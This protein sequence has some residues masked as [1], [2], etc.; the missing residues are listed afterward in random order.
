[1]LE[2][3]LSSLLC[4]GAVLCFMLSCS[5]LYC[6]LWYL[7]MGPWCARLC[8]TVLHTCLIVCCTVCF[9]VCFAVLHCM[10]FCSLLCALLFFTECYAMCCCAQVALPGDWCSPGLAEKLGEQFGATSFGDPLFAAHLALLLLPGTRPAVLRL[11]WNALA[12]DRSLHLLPRTEACLGTASQYLPPYGTCGA[13]ASATTSPATSTTPSA[14]P[15]ALSSS[16][17]PATS[18]APGPSSDVLGMMLRSLAAGDLD[19]AWDMGS[20]SAGVVLHWGLPHVLIRDPSRRPVLD[21]G[22]AV[23]PGSAGAAGSGAAGDRGQAGSKDDAIQ[24]AV[25][26]TRTLVRAMTPDRLKRFIVEGQAQ[27]VAELADQARVLVQSCTGDLA[28]MDKIKVTLG[29]LGLV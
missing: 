28:L 3:P 25:S 10:F 27:G 15:T 22:S 18:A 5:M 8:F 9:T 12:Q 17:A 20:V 6:A 7:N 13:S 1:M 24:R 14:A 29:Q 16:S 26:D 19:K 23:Q 11:L 21:P 2:A 4:L